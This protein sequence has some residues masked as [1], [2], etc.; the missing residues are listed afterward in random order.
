VRHSVG[1]DIIRRAYYPIMVVGPEARAV[2]QAREVMVA[3]DGV[4]DPRPLIDVATCWS[5][6][7]GAVLRVGTV[8]EPV[9][10]DLRSPG[11]FTR[12]HGPAIDPEVYLAKVRIEFAPTAKTVAIPDPVNV[13]AGLLDHLASD[14]AR[15][16]V[17][18]GNH[19]APSFGSRTAAHVLPRARLPLLIVDHT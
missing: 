7:L 19:R 9:L 10:P 11:H 16:L 15:L 8:Y 14:P 2:G 1:S 5:R 6:A 18:G 17:L 4:H 13:A 3:I 12:H